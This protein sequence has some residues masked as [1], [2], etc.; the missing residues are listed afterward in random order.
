MYNTNNAYII[1]PIFLGL[2]YLNFN[3]RILPDKRIFY[4]FVRENLFDSKDKSLSIPND[5][6]QRNDSNSSNEK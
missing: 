1:N 3:K 6:I 2:Y 5:H 4:D